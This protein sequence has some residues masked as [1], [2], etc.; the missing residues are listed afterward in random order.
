[1]RRLWTLLALCICSGACS[2]ACSGRNAQQ[3]TPP[4]VPA[5]PASAAAGDAG[6]A[7]PAPPQP[8]PQPA[9]LTQD[10]AAPYFADGDAAQGVRA[11]SLEKWAEAKAAFTA[12]RAKAQG[13]AAARL[14]LLLGLVHA[15]LGEWPQAVL[16]LTA[17][18]KGLPL[19]GDYIRYQAARACYFAGQLPRALELSREVAADSI[20]GADAELLIGDLL[21]ALLGAKGEHA[22]VAAH[23][24]D[25]LTRRP[26][27][28][29]RA[30]ARFRLAEALEHVSVKDH[31]KEIVALYRQIRIDDPLAAWA[32]QAGDR[33]AALRPTLPAD[34][35]KYDVLTA[36]EHIARGKELFAAQRNPESEAAF[37]AALADKAITAEE[38]CVAAYHRAQSRFKA[39]DRKAAAPM[40]DEAAAA[41]KAGKNTDLEIKGL[42][43]AGRSWSFVGQ[44]EEA[45]KRFQAA[46]VVD[47]S[48]SY[49]DDALLR[50]AEEWTALAQPKQ[51]EAVLSALPTKFPAGD[52]VAEATW[53]LGWAA[54][55]DKQLD[56][57]IKWWKKQ[58]EL[59]PHDDNYYGEGQAQYWLGR[60]YAAKGQPKD[61]LAAYEA[62]ARQY[63]AAYYAMLAL[64]RVREA[65]PKRY[66]QLVAELAADP[67]G[68]DPKAPAFSF[69]P[70]VEWGAPGFA[71]ALEFLRL[72][73]GDA[74]EAELRKLGLTAPRDKKRVDD[75]DTV[76]KL[77]AMAYLFDR[78]GRHSVAHWPTRWHIL[79]YRRE[80]P[81]GPNRARWRIGYPLAYEELVR[82]HATTNKVPFAM[83]IAIVR[84][85]SSYNPLL[86]ST[87]N[88]IGLTQMIS[89]TGERFAKG[90][91]ITVSRDTLRDPEKNVTIGSRFLGYLF[92]FW[93]GFTMLVPPSYNA[94]ENYTRR[95]MKLRGTLAADE[96]V[97]AILDD[98]I[99]N[100]TKRVLG[101]YFTYSWLYE[102]AV[103]EMPNAIPVELIPK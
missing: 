51:A 75:P 64:N 59:I 17:A 49:S 82:T 102:Q 47:P 57:A 68:F 46:Q 70:R 5:I 29:R 90:T 76:E 40:F 32:K 67:K 98:E 18:Q 101:T 74:A 89:V 43:Q 83:Q 93:K 6:P 24:R 19:L 23:Y 1:M 21:R 61:A 86:E 91:G 15:R 8:A 84:E 79:D 78:A 55:Q 16:R 3:V 10:M 81:V 45:A 94:G 39:R 87:A 56:V 66:E 4:L 88:A 28:I 12:A 97:E 85:E 26:D 52:N 100:Y 11:F 35:Q 27:G 38:R 33:L 50:E 42:Y 25:Y 37:D 103:P 96:F 44:H 62:A 77:W 80:W 13:D 72:G 14:D 99:R 71:R 65:A 7:A 63:P 95:V 2:G 22:Q 34:L 53:R 31:A 30:E 36:A 9:P 20:V 73:L 60:A 54:W 92:Q 48:H 41:C 58:I 69:K